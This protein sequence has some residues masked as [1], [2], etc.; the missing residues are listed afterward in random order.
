MKGHFYLA[1]TDDPMVDTITDQGS[2]EEVGEDVMTSMTEPSIFQHL[3]A[4]GI[5]RKRLADAMD[6][7]DPWGK[8]VHAF[9]YV[10]T[11]SV[12]LT[13]WPEEANRLESVPDD[14]MREQYEVSQETPNDFHT[15]PQTGKFPMHEGGQ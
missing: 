8:M 13:V 10:T 14:P 12:L 1:L 3:A 2:M 11:L 9:E 15:R 4:Y 5:T 7:N 6:S